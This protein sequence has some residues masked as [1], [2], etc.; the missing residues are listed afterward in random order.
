MPKMGFLDIRVLRL[1]V[2]INERHGTEFIDRAGSAR[3]EISPLYFLHFWP[4][5]DGSS[6]LIRKDGFSGVYITVYAFVFSRF[7]F[8]FIVNLIA[9]VFVMPLI[10]LVHEL[11]QMH[12]D[13]CRA[14]LEE[15]GT[16]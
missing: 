7:F 14:M 2:C 1:L 5:L 12:I 16:T 6:L 13:R 10:N 9:S 3:L 4:F 15:E 11:M 8:F